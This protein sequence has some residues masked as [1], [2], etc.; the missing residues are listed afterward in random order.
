MAESTVCRSQVADW[1]MALF[2]H[3]ALHRSCQKETVVQVSLL[4]VTL[5]CGRGVLCSDLTHAYCKSESNTGRWGAWH[6]VDELK[7]LT[8]VPA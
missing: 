7:C 3:Q 4:P 1:N 6:L 8:S 2:W 5:D